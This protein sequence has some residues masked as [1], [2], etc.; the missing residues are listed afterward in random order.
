MGMCDFDGLSDEEKIN[1]HSQVSKSAASF[2]GANYFL[3]FLEAIRNTTPHPLMAKNS[4]FKCKLGVV[5]WNKVIFRDKLNL[6]MK[7]RPNEGDNDTLVLNKEDKNYKKVMNLL[8][9]IKPIIF[10]VRPADA[11]AG[12]G[13]QVHPFEVIGDNITRLDLVFDVLFFCPLDT[14]KN[15]LHYTPNG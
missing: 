3:Q 4:E 14:V 7:I 13:F 12:K 6:L 9:T 15:I 1:Y 10:E 5:K 8:R 11:S 2:G